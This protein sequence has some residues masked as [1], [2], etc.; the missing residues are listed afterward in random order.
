MKLRP[1][2]L[3]VTLLLAMLTVVLVSVG[4]TFAFSSLAVQREFR[5]LP[6]DIQTYLRSRDAALRRGETPPAPPV[7]PSSARSTSERPSSAAATSRP[8]A[9]TSATS[10]ASNRTDRPPWP[11][12]QVDWLRGVQRQLLQI[13]LVAVAVSALLALW[14]ARRIARPLTVVSRAAG[15]LAAGELQ[16]RVP[17]PTM[18]R[19]LAALAHS[20]NG[21]AHNLEQLEAERRQ[22]VADIA[23]ELRTPL[24]IMQARLDAMEDGIYPMSSEQIALL[25]TQTQLLTR[26]VGDLRT[27]TL[28]DAG[29][30][31]LN[32]RDTDLGELAQAVT[33]GL[34]TQALER[35]VQLHVVQADA[36]PVSADPDRLRQVL[37]NLIENALRHARAHVD[38]SVSVQGAEVALHVDDDGAGIPAEKRQQV[39]T[40]FT[41]LDESRSRDAGG[42]GLGLSIVQ[43]LATAHGGSAR[44]EA[45]P[46]GGAR[47]SVTVP[48]GVPD[49]PG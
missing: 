18:D 17:V 32:R 46:L 22:A 41:R 12:R 36:A 24:A 30:L 48:L 2:P 13:G 14:L 23:H 39:F 49:A 35:G 45:S 29:Q 1:L 16:V 3:K 43:A 27:L 47:L 38:V 31:A 5:K 28:L 40:R 9:T 33:A 37:S 34:Q 20:F 8:S 25:S 10:T 15:R 11:V 21:M 7:R 42:S 6:P 19:E 44:A 4:G 26:L